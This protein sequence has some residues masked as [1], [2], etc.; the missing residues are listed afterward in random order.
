MRFGAG[1]A[2]LVLQGGGYCFCGGEGGLAVVPVS[3]GHFSVVCRLE[4]GE[5]VDYIPI[6]G[7]GFCERDGGGALY[8][9]R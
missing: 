8:K 3:G 4:R 7:F 6:K 1:C 9:G 2:P 5:G